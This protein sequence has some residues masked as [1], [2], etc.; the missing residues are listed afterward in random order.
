MV[1]ET[2]VDTFGDQDLADQA[3]LP[4]GKKV[5]GEITAVS[6]KDAMPGSFRKFEKPLKDGR[7]EVPIISVQIRARKFADG[8]PI[9]G[10]VN[11][12]FGSDFWVGASDVIGRNSYARLG[13]AVLGLKKEELAGK[14]LITLAQE[15]VGGKVAF[16]VIHRTYTAKDGTEVTQQSPA[17]LKAATAEEAALLV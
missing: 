8:Q 2:F 13:A 14:S 9:E 10:N 17:K 12:F 6:T 11:T 15:I 7:M 1:D 4:A 3:L 5:I 16:D